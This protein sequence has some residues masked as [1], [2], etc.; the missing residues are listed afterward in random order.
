MRA[1]GGRGPHRLPAPSGTCRACSRAMPHTPPA[2]AAGDRRLVQR[3]LAGHDR[4]VDELVEA[5]APGLL[6]FCRARLRRPA[7]A[8][9]EVV[10]AT[11]ARALRKLHTYRAEAALFTWLCAICRRELA[12]YHRRRRR[13]DPEVSL[14]GARSALEDAALARQ[15][16]A[17][18]R[19]ALAS[20]VRAALAALPPRYGKALAWKYLEEARVEEV[21]RRLGVGPKAAESLL[22]RARGAFRRAYGL[23]AP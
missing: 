14:G 4:A 13:T 22:T 2:P 18:S 23:T 3:V 10:Q 15:A 7:G 19:A 9:E 12:A 1:A 11:L 21:A 17:D 5:M 6:R 8:A 20:C 16:A